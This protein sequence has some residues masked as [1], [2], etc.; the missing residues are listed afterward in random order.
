VTIKSQL[1]ELA[2]SIGIYLPI[3]IFYRAS[4]K[5]TVKAEEVFWETRNKGFLNIAVFTLWMFSK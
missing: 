1:Y 3:A 4:H 2:L 5:L